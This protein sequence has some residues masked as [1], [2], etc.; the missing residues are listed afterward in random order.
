MKQIRQLSTE[1]NELMFSEK[2]FFFSSRSSSSIDHLHSKRDSAYSS[3]STSSSIPEYLASTP[4]FSPERCYS[5]ETVPQRGGGSAEMLQTEARGVRS[6]YDGQQGLCKE[7]E[8]CS[9]SAS[10]L[11]SSSSRAGLK[12]GL[13]REGNDAHVSLRLSGVTVSKEVSLSAVPA[14]LESVTVATV[15]APVV[16]TVVASQP[17]TDTVW[18]QY[19]GRQST[20]VPMRA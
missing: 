16:T 20:T 14:Q 12:S 10:T 3:F 17:L 11:G 2:C 5:L 7:N 4:S 19:G 9:G 6:G 8:L 1:I 18:G 15:V 13:G